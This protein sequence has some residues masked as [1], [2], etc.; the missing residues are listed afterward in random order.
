MRRS[1]YRINDIIHFILMLAKEAYRIMK[2]CVVKPN[3]R[4]NVCE[5]C[6]KCSSG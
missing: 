5:K 2:K 1:I 6:V 4:E 3:L